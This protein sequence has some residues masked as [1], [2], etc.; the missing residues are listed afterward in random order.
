[1]VINKN[2]SVENKH[3]KLK[4]LSWNINSLNT[5]F[6]ELLGHIHNNKYD[7][8]ALQETHI[9]KHERFRFNIPSFKIYHHYQNTD[10]KKHGLLIAINKNIPSTYISV[11][12]AK[13]N[14]SQELIIINS[15]LPK[16]TIQLQNYY[17][18]PSLKVKEFNP[19]INCPKTSLPFY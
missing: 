16:Q 3:T 2:S 10:L 12:N 11:P 17:F 18:S 4:I 19:L 5:T 14:T 15:H 13:S 8:I 1:M 7:I 6:V 9:S